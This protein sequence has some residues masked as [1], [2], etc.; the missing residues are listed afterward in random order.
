MPIAKKFSIWPILTHFQPILLSE[1]ELDRS[2][3]YLPWKIRRVVIRCKAEVAT[4]KVPS[5]TWKR[6]LVNHRYG[7]VLLRWYYAAAVLERLWGW[8]SKRGFKHR[9]DL[10]YSK[11]PTFHRGEEIFLCYMELTSHS[12]GYRTKEMVQSNWIVP[13]HSLI[14]VR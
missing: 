12:S 5:T 10:I 7:T 3:K 4:L 8:C 11:N 6:C 13:D 9:K 2:P 14:F 1:P